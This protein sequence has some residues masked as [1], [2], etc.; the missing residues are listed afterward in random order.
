M[1]SH[2]VRRRVN[3]TCSD[4]SP[5]RAGGGQADQSVQWRRARVT[6]QYN[7]RE[8]QRRLEVERWIDRGLDLLYRGRVSTAVLLQNI[9]TSRDKTIDQIRQDKT[10]PDQTR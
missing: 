5:G 10:R 6:V 1:A 9:K 4:G 7:R 8:L 2:R 3:R